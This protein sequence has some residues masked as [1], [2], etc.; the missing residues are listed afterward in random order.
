MAFLLMV[1]WAVQLKL[2]GELEVVLHD[3]LNDF[4]ECSMFGRPRNPY[5]LSRVADLHKPEIGLACR[6]GSL[7]WG[8][9]PLD[10][11]G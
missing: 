3:S 9:Q 7:S 11:G 1:W 2:G 4:E 10:P 6:L 8:R 5:L